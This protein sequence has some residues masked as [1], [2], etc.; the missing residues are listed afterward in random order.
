[1]KYN[2][3]IIQSKTKINSYSKELEKINYTMDKYQKSYFFFLQYRFNGM[4]IDTLRQLNSRKQSDILD[5]D[6]E[7]YHK[8]II[9]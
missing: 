5:L 3:I 8:Y 2:N 4:T 7:V 9:A 1:M 6:D